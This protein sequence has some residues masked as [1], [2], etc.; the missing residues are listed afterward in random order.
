MLRENLS[1]RAASYARLVIHSAGSLL[2]IVSDILDVSR[3]DSGRLEL[4]C[5][6]FDPRRAVEQT[7]GIFAFAAEDKGLEFSVHVAP[8]VP[9]CLVGD[10]FRYRQVLANL[11]GNAV[12]FTERGSVCLDVDVAPG[13]G[14]NR[15]SPASRRMRPCGCWGGARTSIGFWSGNFWRTPRNW[16]QPLRRLPG[17][18]TARKPAVSCTP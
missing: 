17:A 18:A 5:R 14:P 8:E 15:A 9:D 11:L 13:P 4:E 6:P 10:A 1:P 16:P 12:K 3:L 7:S 2:E